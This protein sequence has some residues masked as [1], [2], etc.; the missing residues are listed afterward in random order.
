[1]TETAPLIAK[2][3]RTRLEKVAS[4]GNAIKGMEIAIEADGVIVNTPH[5]KERLL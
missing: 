2:H 1:M 3:R 5:V 4:V